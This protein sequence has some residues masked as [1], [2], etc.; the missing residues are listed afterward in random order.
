[1]RHAPV[2]A[3][4]TAAGIVLLAIPAVAQDVG[5]LAGHRAEERALR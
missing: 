5:I 1:M 4:I 3:L 2:A